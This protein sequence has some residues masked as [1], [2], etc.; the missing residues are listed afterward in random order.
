[1]LRYAARECRG[2]SIPGKEK[3]MSLE[4]NKKIAVTLFE[5]MSS[6][7]IDAVLD[8]FAHDGRWWVL[9][10]TYFGELLTKD[11][12]RKSLRSMAIGV[13]NG[14]NLKISRVIAEG[15]NV[16][17]EADGNAPTAGGKTY[18]NHYVWVL[19]IRDGKVLEGREFMDTLHVMETFGPV[20]RA[21]DKA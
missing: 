8:A 5:N 9:G 12:M 16:V 6:L 2:P 21:K 14:L 13:P 4:E 19:T 11:Q 20:L 3:S 17:V 18:A 1:M 7:K 15:D 10:G